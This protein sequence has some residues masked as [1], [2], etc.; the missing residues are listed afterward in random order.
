M[1]AMQRING[2]EEGSTVARTLPPPPLPTNLEAQES[3]SSYED[4]AN[5]EAEA[6]GD[7]QRAGDDENE[8][9]ERGK[10]EAESIVREVMARPVSLSS[11]QSHLE[12]RGIDLSLATVRGSLPDISLACPPS[13]MA[14][15]E[16]SWRYV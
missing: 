11:T 12:D 13:P 6:G 7:G 16:A 1:Q 5:R 10:E 8:L 3:L 9:A 14:M 2:G 15:E 4:G